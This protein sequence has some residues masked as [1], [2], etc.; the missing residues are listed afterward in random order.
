MVDNSKNLFSKIIN[1][2]NPKDENQ[3]NDLKK[4]LNSYPY[5]QSASAYYLKSLR[6]RENEAY[7]ELLP[8]TA[9]LTSNRVILRDWLFKSIEI[10]IS[11]NS[12]TEKYSFL[13]W[14][15]IIDDNEQQVEKKFDLIDQFIKNSPKIQFSQEKKS[16]PEIKISAKIKDELITETLAK[17]YVT[18]KKFNKAIKAYEILSLKYP[19]KSSFFADQIIDIKK[20]KSKD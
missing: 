12:K 19:K 2:F 10:V 11:D 3:A 4:I 1:D 20:L 5:F 14:F 13:D 6:A 18:Q 8:K 15:D 7:N 9:L 16:E 17:I